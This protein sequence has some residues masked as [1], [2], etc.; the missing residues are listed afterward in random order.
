[1][2]QKNRRQDKAAKELQAGS[3]HHQGSAHESTSIHSQGVIFRLQP[4]HGN[5]QAGSPST[6]YPVPASTL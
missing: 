5:S 4:P 1:M 3:T 2:E 6:Q